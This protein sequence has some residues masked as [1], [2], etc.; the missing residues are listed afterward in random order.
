MAGGSN[1]TETKR[2]ILGYHRISVACGQCRPQDIMDTIPCPWHCHFVW[3]QAANQGISGFSFDAIASGLT[4]F[5]VHCRRRKIRCLIAPGHTQEC[6]Q[7]CVRLRKDCRFYRVNPK[8]SA[9]KKGALSPKLVPSFSEH[10]ATIL[11]TS[12]NPEP[13]YMLYPRGPFLL[14]DY[15]SPHQSTSAG[16]PSMNLK[17]GKSDYSRCTKQVP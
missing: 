16:Y 11:P 14:E 9:E 1:T 5:L 6:C 7:N 4:V 13:M 17:T 15:A 12:L 10:S 8:L 2:N 3:G